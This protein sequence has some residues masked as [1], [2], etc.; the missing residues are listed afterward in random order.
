[1]QLGLVG[2]ILANTALSIYFLW[3]VR[4][5]WTDSAVARWELWAQGTVWILTFICAF[6]PIPME[7][8]NSN[9]ET[10]YI[11]TVPPECSGDDCIRGSDPTIHHLVFAFLPFAC[12][13]VILAIMTSLFVRVRQVEDGSAKYA[14]RSMAAPAI[15]SVS[16]GSS[17]RDSVF[18]FLVHRV[19]QLI[20][21]TQNPVVDRRNSLA[22]RRQAVLYALAFFFTYIFTLISTIRYHSMVPGMSNWTTL[23]SWYFIHRRGHSTFWFLQDHES[24]WKLGRVVF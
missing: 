18:S 9:A 19:S 15:S 16:S 17:V 11:G 3:V 21:P 1:M 12:L 8:Y 5:G 20:S 2:S 14:A 6:Y 4:F 10:C 7:L 13:V 23:V 24:K 22:V